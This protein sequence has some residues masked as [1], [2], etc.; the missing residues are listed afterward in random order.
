[1][2]PDFNDDGYLPPGVHLATLDEGSLHASERETELRTCADR[3]VGVWLVEMA[4]PCW[5]LTADRQRQFRHGPAR[6]L[7]M[8]IAY[9]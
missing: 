3:V 9:S 6:T 1:M 8:S 4:R 7:T 2:L 5:R